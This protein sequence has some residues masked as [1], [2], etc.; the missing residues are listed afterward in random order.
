[1]THNDDDP[2]EMICPY[3]GHICQTTSIGAV[4]CGPHVSSADGNVSPA[5][6]MREKQ[7]VDVEAHEAL[8]RTMDKFDAAFLDAK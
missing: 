2:R 8:D 4:Y 5:V 1:M 3:C 7:N 6:Q